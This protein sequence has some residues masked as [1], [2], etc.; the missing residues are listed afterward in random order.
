MFHYDSELKWIY[1]VGTYLALLLELVL[2]VYTLYSLFQN[3]E[4]KK[5]ELRFIRNI[6]LSDLLWCIVN[7]IA[8][9]YDP[10]NTHP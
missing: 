5:E 4:W 3:Q 2:L 7:L 1:L 9:I 8:F 6:L 10:F